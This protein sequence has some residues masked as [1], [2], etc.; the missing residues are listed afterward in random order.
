MVRPVFR[1]APSPN[2]PLHIG[3][4]F[5]AIL[6]ANLAKRTGGRFLLRIEDIDQSR[7]R[8]GFVD[9][10]F[11][12]LAWL[13]LEWETPVRI[14]SAHFNDY[15]QALNRLAEHG[16]LYA[17]TLSRGQ[18]NQLV[19]DFERD[20]T[21]WPRDPDGAPLYPPGERLNP[22]AMNAPHARQHAIRLNMDKAL[23]RVGKLVERLH[24]REFDASDPDITTEIAGAPGAWGDVVVARVDCPTSYHLSVVVDDALQGVTHVVRGHDLSHTTSVHRLLQV[25]LD[26]PQPIYHHHHL[27][28]DRENEKLSKSAGHP[29]LKSLRDRGAT[30]ADIFARI[31]IETL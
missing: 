22:P 4:A 17:A 7:A 3:H 18:R 11:D 24:W 5:S 12:D 2:G 31:G 9:G 13:G 26:L 6:N 21:L 10:I 23:E 19:T 25:M 30:P 20:G 1:F 16:L 14:Q 28:R 15:A 27:I 8:P 29:G